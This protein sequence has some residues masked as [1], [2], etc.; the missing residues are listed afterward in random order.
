MLRWGARAGGVSSPAS[1]RSWRGRCPL[2]LLFTTFLFIN[3]EVWQVAGTLDGLPYVL[4]IAIF[5][6]LGA[7]FVLSR[8]PATSAGARFATWAEVAAYLDDTPAP[9]SACRPTSRWSTRGVGSAST[10]AWSSS[11]ARPCRSPFV[12]VLIVFFVLFGVLAIPARR[13]PAGPAS[14]T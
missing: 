11:S 12:A 6:L 8:V 14:T 7:T 10:S 2:L 4:V 9:S 5:F 3:A 13:W 1:A